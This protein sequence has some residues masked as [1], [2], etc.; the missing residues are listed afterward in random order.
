MVRTRHVAAGFAALV[1][2]L[3]SALA[4]AQDLG[5]VKVGVLEFGTVTWELD[6]IK[7]NGLDAKHGFNLE[8]QPFGSGQASRRCAQ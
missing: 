2:A 1:V 5:T 7:H 6:V 3:A 8:V 4:S